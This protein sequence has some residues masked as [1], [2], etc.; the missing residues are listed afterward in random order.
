MPASLYGQRSTLGVNDV[1][2]HISIEDQVEN[3]PKMRRELINRLGGKNFKKEVKSHKYEW[4]SRDN[5]KL[6]TTTAIDAADSA[7]SIVVS[8]PGVLNVDDAIMIGTAT[9][10]V[11]AVAGGVNATIRKIAGTQTAAPLG[12]DVVIIGGATAQGKNAD[13]MVISGFDD[14]FNFTSIIEDVV[15]L[16]GTD[17]AA[18]I[19]GEE[20]SG[21]LIARKQMELTEKLQRALI[22]SPR[23]EDKARKTTTMGGLKYLIDTSERS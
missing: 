11:E 18:M 10:V 8:D 22:V 5:R 4:S 7:T 14:Y 1:E 3:F 21:Q 9:F 12:T 15:D 6:Q 2:L 23:T 17:H 20:N 19:R 13:N 16:S